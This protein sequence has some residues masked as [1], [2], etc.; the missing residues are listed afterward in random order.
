[1]AWFW[2]G[3]IDLELIP[4]LHLF[5][6]L[7]NFLIILIKELPFLIKNCIFERVSSGWVGCR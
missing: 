1:M 3:N 7:G 6:N 4:L 2:L 5:I